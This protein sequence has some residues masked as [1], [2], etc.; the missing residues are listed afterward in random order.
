MR[1]S[2]S[3][4]ASAR[5]AG[6]NASRS[7][8]DERLRRNEVQHVSSSQG[9][10][11]SP[12]TTNPKYAP[13]P[14]SNTS[15]N[16]PLIKKE[17]PSS[18]EA[19][20]QQ[21]S[22][23]QPSARHRPR[24]LDLSRNSNKPIPPGASTV[25]ARPSAKDSA[26]LGVM[27]DV[28]I[29]CLSPGFHSHDPEVKVQLQKSMD[30]RE[31]Q[32]RTIESRMHGKPPGPG[33]DKKTGDGTTPSSE[34]GK[35]L[36]TSRRKGPPPGLNIR[37]PSAQEFAS[38][39]RVIQ[40]APLNQTFTGLHPKH[41]PSLSRQVLDRPP[42]P[43]AAASQYPQHTPS[44]SSNR[45]PPISDVLDS[46]RGPPSGFHAPH[47]NYSPAHPGASA[48]AMA[49]PGYPQP[50]ASAGLQPP[51]SQPAGQSH[52]PSSREGYPSSSRHRDFKSAEEAV[53]SLSGG[54]EDLQPRVVHYGGHQPPTPPSPRHHG[55]H[56]APPTS[57]PVPQYAGRSDSGRRRTREEYERDLNEADRMDVDPRERD[58]DWERRRA[59]AM[60][61]ERRYAA[62]ED[63]RGRQ[64]PPATNHYG[65]P[66]DS[67]ETERRKKEEFMALC[68]RAWDLLHS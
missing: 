26:G 46:A 33:G 66:L 32:R 52:N 67:P 36:G 30:I 19:A 53:Q 34:F 10:S 9:G 40:S 54:R 7:P 14:T 11:K 21:S 29:A 57:Q 1:R 18:P 49:S 61:D 38:E 6:N 23:P 4:G 17:H 25:G 12:A 60:N 68:S 5:A 59:A 43:G 47:S 39:P 63:D 22:Y 8:S 45:L 64:P 35:P 56:K 44:H 31:S 13:K 48:T 50:P 27:H 3:S 41:P 65:R 42:P 16:V 51:R 37:A 2:M 24:K 15:P 58:H 55:E 62:W 28:G 20:A